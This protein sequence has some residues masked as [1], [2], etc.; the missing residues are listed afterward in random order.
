MNYL[1]LVEETN[2]SGFFSTH[3]TQ[4]AEKQQFEVSVSLGVSQDN[5]EGWQSKILVKY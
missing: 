5:A 3:S 1:R 4:Q 2:D